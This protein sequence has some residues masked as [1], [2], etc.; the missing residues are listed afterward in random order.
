MNHE[1]ILQIFSGGFLGKPVPYEKVEQKLL[2]VLSRLP[3]AKV[4]MGWALDR[5]LY[6]RTA[7]FLAKRGIDFYVWF[8]VFS[9]TGALR[10]LSG[11]VDFHGSRVEGGGTHSDED[12][13]FCCPNS[14]QNIDSIL[15]IFE[16]EFAPVPFNGIFLDKIRFPSFAQGQRPGQ[17]WSSVFSCFCPKCMALYEQEGFK[18]EQ[19][20]KALSQS[21]STPLGIKE[22]H[23]NGNYS[24]EAPVVSRFFSLKA[25]FIFQNLKRI[26]RYF[27][28]K[29][30]GIGLDVFAPFLAPFTGQDLMAL[31]GLAGFIK[32]MMYRA[33]RAPAGL[34]YETEML[35]RETGCDGDEKRQKFF[36]LL[37]LDSEQKPF[38]LAFS[39]NELKQTAA[40]S[41]C[42]VYA[43][44]E[45]NR[46]KKI[47]EVYPGYIKETIDAFSRTGIRGFTLS[48]DLL[49]APEENITAVA[50]TINRT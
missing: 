23:G 47:A 2:S 19:L 35:L 29:G 18:P 6:E 32:P 42:P 30:L 45:I 12:F 1:I 27:R 41:S 36:K 38:D 22:Y 21:A 48:W 9:E 37:G 33:T 3:V 4:I 20:K 11:L 10:P 43:G 16:R 34:P 15:D 25:A 17:G 13:S 40:A 14:K 28:E 7:A 31:S 50:D 44:V 26:C 24:F 5:E 39:A 49:D 46:K 8:P